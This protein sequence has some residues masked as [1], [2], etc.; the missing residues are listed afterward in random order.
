MLSL[1]DEFDYSPRRSSQE[2]GALKIENC[3][4]SSCADDTPKKPENKSNESSVI[5]RLQDSSASIIELAS[6]SNYE[7]N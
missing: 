5:E 1:G 4:D 3:K 2:A 6:E 7:S